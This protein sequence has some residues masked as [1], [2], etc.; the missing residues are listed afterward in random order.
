MLAFS[1]IVFRKVVTFSTKAGSDLE[2]EPRYELIQ[3]ASHST[4]ELT[5]L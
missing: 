3:Q 2:N 5:E 1:G 4:A